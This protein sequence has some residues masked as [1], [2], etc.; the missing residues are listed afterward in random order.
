[1]FQGRPV[2]FWWARDENHW[3]LLSCRVSPILRCV[4][5]DEGK[6]WFLLRKFGEM[7]HDSFFYVFWAQAPAR[8]LYYPNYIGGF[9]Q[10]QLQASPLKTIQSKSSWKVTGGFFVAHVEEN[11]TF[12]NRDA[13]SICFSQNIGGNNQFKLRLVLMF[14][15]W[16]LTIFKYSSLIIVENE[17][18]GVPKPAWLQ[19]CL[20]ILPLIPLEIG[21]KDGEKKQESK[22][23]NV[24]GIEVES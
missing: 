11:K 14:S 3:V 9:F 7:I 13:R 18:L 1:M 6:P 23:A 21:T 12:Q 8:G 2:N 10:R 20:V 17:P 19:G 24:E 16:N 5:S 22:D 15:F 4:S